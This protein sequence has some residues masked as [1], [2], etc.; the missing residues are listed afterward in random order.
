V[1]IKI[2]K[3]QYFPVIGDE[4]RDISGKEQFAS[5]LATIIHGSPNCPAQFK[6]L[7]EEFS[8]RLPGLKP[9]CPTRWTVCT[10][11]AHAVISNY[12]IIFLELE[13]N[14]TKLIQKEVGKQL[15]L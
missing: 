9:L 11:A 5:E 4:A 7:Q 6:C 13:K 1:L 15:E 14:G 12:S 10:G 8:K 3:A 2:H